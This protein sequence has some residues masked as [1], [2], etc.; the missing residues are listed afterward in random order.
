MAALVAHHSGA[1]FVPL[2]RRFDTLLADFTF[3][4]SPV[5]DA[6][7]YADQ[8]VGPNG[9]RITVPYRIAEAITRHG[10]D[11]P[12]ARARVDR[13]PYLLAVADRLDCDWPIN[14]PSSRVTGVL[15]IDRGCSFSCGLVEAPSGDSEQIP[16]HRGGRGL[17]DQPS[18]LPEPVSA[19]NA[20]T[21]G[22]DHLELSTIRPFTPAHPAVPQRVNDLAGTESPSNQSIMNVR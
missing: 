13:V 8:T 6:L 11:S 4:D 5:S 16:T 9:R 19:L 18:E 10:P 2:E 21:K 1:R 15:R 7:T 17:R 3:E 22:V 14:P 12:N 20:A